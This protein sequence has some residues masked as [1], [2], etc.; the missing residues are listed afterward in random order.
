M[1]V[2]TGYAKG[3][4]YDSH[5]CLDITEKPNHAW[6]ALKF[7][8]EWRLVD[9]TWDAGF[10]EGETYFPKEGYFYFLTDPEIFSNDHFP[11]MANNMR[12]SAKWQLLSETWTF[13]KFSKHVKYEK[14][15]FDCDLETSITDAII[16]VDKETEILITEHGKPLF[17]ISADLTS[18]H[19]INYDRYVF[20][21]R[22]GIL[23]DEDE[24]EKE[25]TMEMKV[26][27]FIRPPEVC[28]YKL[29]IYGTL[30]DGDE[31][32]SLLEYA[33][34][35][36]NVIEDMFP[37]P[38]HFGMWGAVTGY[39]EYGFDESVTEQCM[40]ECENGE[41]VVTLNAICE[42]D[43][44]A[45]LLYYADSEQE[46]SYVFCE[47]DELSFNVSAR[48]EKEGFYKLIVRAKKLQSD[49]TS[50][51]PVINYLIDCKIPLD[52]CEK[53]PFAYPASMIFGVHL[54]QPLV[55]Y[56][57]SNRDIK[58]VMKSSTL[59]R[60]NMNKQEIHEPKKVDETLL[61]TRNTGLVDV[62]SV[63]RPNKKLIVDDQPKDWTLTAVSM[64]GRSGFEYNIYGSTEESGPFESLY[65]FDV[66][67]SPSI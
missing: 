58:F 42:F 33:I 54:V 9:C 34:L 4:G 10:V 45:G 49:D 64:T 18:E 2:I 1:E 11:Y 29:K 51:W 8:G 35:C 15:W 27:I 22:R 57:P 19:G 24:D 66:E 26:R 41:L 31:M 16:E 48:L 21:D 6:N 47:R 3:Y 62:K 23:N 50:Y 36:N 61:A 17:T 39:S 7:D 12:G 28:S 14:C 46:L 56:I 20:I 44:A 25:W 32:E 63:N 38:E 59:K 37:Y 43:I 60:V 52:P 30:E 65:V 40:F 5:K 67:E 53:Y 13:E 55:K